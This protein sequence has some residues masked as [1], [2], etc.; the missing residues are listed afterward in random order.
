MYRPVCKSVEIYT[1]PASSLACLFRATVPALGPAAWV[2][3]GGGA[4]AH[5]QPAVPFA[6]TLFRLRAARRGRA[7]GGH[8]PSQA[9]F[10]IAINRNLFMRITTTGH[11]ALAPLI[12]SLGATDSVTAEPHET[13]AFAGKFLR[14]GC[15]LYFGFAAGLGSRNARCLL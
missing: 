14:A 15:C 3:L 11:G 9:A 10:P 5:R 12:Q 6:P 7:G 1:S 8:A 4:S 2:C 13:G